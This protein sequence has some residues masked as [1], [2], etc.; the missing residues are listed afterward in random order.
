MIR[1]SKSKME[2]IV[3]FSEIAV[4]LAHDFRITKMKNKLINTKQTE[5][6]LKRTF[7][8]L[9]INYTTKGSIIGIDFNLFI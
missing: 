7:Y 3:G 9:W 4:H 2:V 6:N 8:K 1:C 5:V